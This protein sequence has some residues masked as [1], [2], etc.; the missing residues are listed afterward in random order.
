[1]NETQL[2]RYRATADFHARV[3]G[4]EFTYPE[5]APLFRA[6]LF[7]PAEWADL[8]ARSG[9]KYVVLTSKHHDGYCLWPSQ[10]ADRTWG[11]AWNSTNIGPNRDLL[12]DLT[13]AVRAAGLKMGIY[14]S[15]YEWF[16]PLWLSDQDRYVTEHMIP[17]FKD[18]VSRYAPAVI[19]SDGEWDMPASR[20]KS[21][22]LVA[23]V[24]N[25]A[26]SR[27]EIVLDDRWGS[28]TRHKHGDYFTTEYGGGMSGAEHAWEE[29]RGMG[30]S[31]GYN[32]SENIDDYKG[33]RE[34]ILILVDMVSRG[35]N[36]LLDV[37]P[38]ADGRI[39]VIM[40]DRLINMGD[41]LQVNG[42]AIY[43][44][45]AWIRPCQWTAGQRPDLEFKPY[46][47]KYDIL[48]R[49]GNQPVK[50]IARIQLFFTQKNQEL[51]A[52][53]PVWPG[54]RL[55]IPDLEVTSEA[56]IE[57]LGSKAMLTWQEY[58]TGIIVDLSG[59]TAA[60]LAC[61]SIWTLRISGIDD[62]E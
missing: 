7:D 50:G 13:Q 32:R 19:F 21:E 49:I 12:G 41:W 56:K 8:F 40:Q 27:D 57:L 51:Y 46:M 17:Q 47:A 55:R 10:E 59:V 18:V 60:E 36:L 48:E 22:E 33:T 29:S 9:A 30:H 35:G 26:P 28:D 43:G 44:T 5:F 54:K 58:K 45:N 62:K 39:P 14:Y 15:L 34:L 24:Y 11:R 4:K 53:M 2:A 31:Y 38:T 20:W 25:H 3:F 6:E 61:R 1:L 52:I 23:W 42:E 37:G 16:N